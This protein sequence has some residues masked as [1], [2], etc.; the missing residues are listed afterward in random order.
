[1]A[2]DVLTSSSGLFY[3]Q[4][5]RN[6]FQI[7]STTLLPCL[8]ER[9]IPLY[10]KKKKNENDESPIIRRILYVLKYP[11]YVSFPLGYS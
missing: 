3:G 11:N 1:M 6:Y 5:H 4:S 10:K 7:V 9:Y 2:L 8:W